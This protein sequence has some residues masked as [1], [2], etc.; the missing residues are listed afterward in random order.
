MG[1]HHICHIRAATGKAL[2]IHSV[3]VHIHGNHRVSL[4]PKHSVCLLV[5]GVFHG[6]FPSVSQNLGQKHQQVLASRANE[7]LFRPAVHP[8]GR[9]EV[10][11]YG[12]SESSLSLRV[13]CRK[14]LLVIIYQC[15]P[16]DFPPSI[17]G[18]AV[19]INSSGRKIHL[20]TVFPGISRLYKGASALLP[21][22]HQFLYL[23]DK[24][25]FAW[26]CLD[27]SFGQ[28]LVIGHLGGTAAQPQVPGQYAGGGQTASRLQ[29]SPA[30]FIFYVLVNLFIERTVRLAVKRYYQFH[31]P[32]LPAA[33]WH[34]HSYLKQTF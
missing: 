29:L 4:P 12:S 5:C 3:P 11:S 2:H 34:H 17:K 20:I 22:L 27:I 13:P 21:Y 25:A 19:Q 1:R 10:I 16:A 32:P 26:Q 8:P 30:D 7:N 9:M 14:H 18:K 6:N 31:F 33:N 23:T 15:I 28:Q 24:I